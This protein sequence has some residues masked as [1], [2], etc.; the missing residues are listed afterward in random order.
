MAAET[1]TSLAIGCYP[2]FAD[3]LIDGKYPN[4]RDMHKEPALK[5]CHCHEEITS[6]KGGYFAFSKVE[7]VFKVY[8][9]AH[10]ADLR[11]CVT[12]LLL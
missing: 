9:K 7:K 5:C 8:C 10:G 4:H 2:V 3:K 6:K 11:P 1:K 12:E